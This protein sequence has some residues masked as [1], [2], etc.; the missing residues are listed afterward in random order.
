MTLK[1]ASNCYHYEEVGISYDYKECLLYV[2][3]KQINGRLSSV[4]SDELQERVDHADSCT[5][6][7]MSLCPGL[8][9]L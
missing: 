8:T 2:I 6:C 7:F 9:Q 4:T 3:S 1:R 5:L